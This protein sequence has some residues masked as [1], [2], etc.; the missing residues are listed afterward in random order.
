MAR[1]SVP[2]DA[3]ALVVGVACL[4]FSYP[5]SDQPVAE[6]LAR[7]AVGLGWGNADNPFGKVIPEGAHVLVKPNLVFHQNEGSGGIDCVVTHASLIRTATAAA[8]RSGAAEVLVGDAPV[9][10]CDFETLIARTGLGRWAR[11]LMAREP[12]FKGLRDLR[13]TTSRLVHGV[14]LTAPIPHS[15]DHFT[16]FDLGPES[17]LEPITGHDDRFRAAWEN[18]RLLAHR[19]QTGTHQYLLAND[20]LRANVVIS[21]PKLKTHKKAG[22][23]CAL[24][25][26]IGVNASKEFLPHHTSGG[27]PVRGDAYPR[28]GV[29]KRAMEYVA[30]RQNM[31][32]SYAEAILYWTCFALLA[33][34]SRSWGD[35]IGVDGSWSGNNTIW[36][37]CLDLNRIILY[38]RSD[39]KMS[40]DI[41]RRVIHIADAVVAGQGNGPLAPDPLELGLLLGA[42]NPAAMD[43]VGALLLAYV[44]EKIPLVTHA[45]DDFRWPISRWT[46]SGVQLI[47]DLGF[48]KPGDILDPIRRNVCH[49]LGWMD[50][51][52][53]ARANAPN[54]PIA[55][56]F[57]D[58]EDA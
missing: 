18:H 46:S 5:A 12:R 42:N 44:P 31:A 33:H 57:T 51:G 9:Q 26:L 7:L 43:W 52:A 41:Q 29:I 13:R 39:G 30:D 4:S 35:R 49:P 6:A 50:A 32:S 27:S 38:G 53:R 45:F 14:R 3:F 36:R 56:L 20:V 37:T 58:P 40:T 47:G 11:E 54:R 28:G 24:K 55:D 17:L 15:V 25:N 21:L 8:L 16:L 23:T 2:N 19:H 1:P 22:V 10:G 34:G 48:G